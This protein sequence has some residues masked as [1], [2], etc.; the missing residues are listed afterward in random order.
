[1]KKSKREAHYSEG[2]GT[3]RCRNCHFYYRGTCDK[4]H[5]RIDPSYW[6]EL[7]SRAKV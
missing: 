1:M 3:S 7:F 2:M 6:C 4:V 5:G